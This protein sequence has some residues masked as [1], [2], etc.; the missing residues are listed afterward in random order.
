MLKSYVLLLVIYINIHLSCFRRFFIA[1]STYVIYCLLV[2]SSSVLLMGA[3]HSGSSVWPACGGATLGG[4][5]ASIVGESCPRALRPWDG[6]LSVWVG[7]VS[8]V[9]SPVVVGLDSSQWGWLP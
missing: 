4:A 6:P 5:Q 3:L 1:F 7:V 8:V 2:S 9:A